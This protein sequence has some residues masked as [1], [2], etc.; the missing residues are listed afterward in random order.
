MEGPQS[1]RRRLEDGLSGESADAGRQALDEF[2]AGPWGKKYPAIAQSW[3]RHWEQVIPFFAFPVAVRR[4]IYTTNAIEALNAKLRRA[5]RTRGHFSTD[6]AE[7]K[8]LTE[9]IEGDRAPKRS[10]PR[11]R[12]LDYVSFAMLVTLIRGARAVIFPSL[13]EGFGLPVLESMVLG[14]PVVASREA[15]LPE[16]AGD[17]ALLVDP[18]DTDQI[19]RAIITIVHDADLRAE[20]SRRGPLQAAKFSID[21][22]R[23]R[24]SALYG[25]LC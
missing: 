2:D 14:T 18:Y 4:I 21:R 11:I 10:G 6:E 17:A 22:Y 15:A 12:R 1:H 5:V 24:V 25:S 3:R 20:L 23:H 8:L 13:Y 9:H 16:V 7:M 19:A